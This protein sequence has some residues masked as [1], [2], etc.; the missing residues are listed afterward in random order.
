MVRV[1][2]LAR[3]A[4]LVDGRRL[5][6]FGAGLVGVQPVERLREHVCPV[7]GAVDLE[8]GTAARK[9][10]TTYGRSDEAAA[11]GSNAAIPRRP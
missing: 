7:P 8:A 9:G 6:K 3:S 5:R 10:N 1:V 2:D 11:T 4:V